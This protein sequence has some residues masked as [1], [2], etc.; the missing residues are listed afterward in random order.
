M[1]AFL[2]AGAMNVISSLE[3]KKFEKIIWKDLEGLGRCSDGD[4]SKVL[5][6]KM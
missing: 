6:V 4:C 1:I 5:K 3:K 2:I